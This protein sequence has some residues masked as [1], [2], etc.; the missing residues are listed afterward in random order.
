MQYLELE[1]LKKKQAAEKE[2]IAMDFSKKL[3]LGNS[4]DEN[5]AATG[6][7]NEAKMYP[8][9][10]RQSKKNRKKNKK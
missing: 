10:N 1:N 6:E 5:T 7:D 3:K 8:E 4:N 9:A 2:D